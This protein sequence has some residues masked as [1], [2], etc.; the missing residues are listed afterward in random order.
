MAIEL[1]DTPQPEVDV[2]ETPEQAAEADEL[3]Q[4]VA[5]AYHLM[6]ERRRASDEQE[7]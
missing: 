5:T 3:R 4:F 1:V 6:I 7:N 2:A